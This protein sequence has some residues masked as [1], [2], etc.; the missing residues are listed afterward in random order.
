MTMTDRDFAGASTV[1]VMRLVA[2]SREVVWR[3]W[4]DSRHLA[5]WWGPYGYT[6]PEC[7]VDPRPGGRIRILM[8]SVEGVEYLTV[9]TVES[10]LPPERLVFTIG[11]LGPDGNPTLTNHTTVEFE[12]HGPHT[13]V[14]V[15][16]KAQLLSS[17]ALDSLTGM[18]EGWIE[19][20]TRLA[21]MIEDGSGQWVA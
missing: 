1:V 19:S 4:T 8:R 2:A 3:M 18:R 13:K 7:E 14:I 15:R 5:A 11:L 6:N 17:E 12:E 9:G 10:A 21:A 20:L 16:V